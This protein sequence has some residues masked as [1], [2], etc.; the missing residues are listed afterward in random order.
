MIRKAA[1]LA[2]AFVAVV[3]A[4]GAS[5]E[6]SAALRKP[7]YAPGD[8]WVYLLD[9]SLSGLP[10]LNETQ[11]GTFQ[12]GLVGRVDVDVIGPSLRPRDTGPM[13]ALRVD[14]RTTGYL[15]GT[16]QFPPGGPPGS[17]AVRGTFTASASEYWENASYFPIESHATSSYVADIMY[18]L[19]FSFRADLRVDATTTAGSIPP[20]EL[21]VGDTGTVELSTLL[22][23]N[24][25]IT[26]AGQTQ[27][28]ANE[29]RVPSTWRREVVAT[30][31]VTVEAGRFS[32]YKLNQSLGGFPGLP[33]LVA[34][35]NESAYFSNDA[36]YY[37][38]RVAY[39]NGTPVSEMRLKSYAYAAGPH[40][41][42]LDSVILFVLILVPVAVALLLALFYR[43]RRKERSEGR[44]SKETT[45]V[46][47]R[48]EEGG[49]GPAR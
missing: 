48:R 45:A 33:A 27:T 12:F 38:K 32:T 9:G 40:P 21:D 20:F 6:A 7:V 35:G 29:T 44:G 30:E 24:S 46:R 23:T 2:I 39:E 26:F 34:I 11:T 41:A 15:N 43:K 3:A 36:G 18:G 1:C 22:A 28:R 13:W 49:H 4:L 5:R 14:T 37:A 47:A 16:F 19:T 10:G 25:T 31:P 8:H 17:A 42:G